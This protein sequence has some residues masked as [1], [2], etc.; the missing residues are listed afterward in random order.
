MIK[1][2][3]QPILESMKFRIFNKMLLPF[4]YFLS[5]MNSTLP[6]YLK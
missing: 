3:V 5:Q 1:K 4:F 2:P 6:F